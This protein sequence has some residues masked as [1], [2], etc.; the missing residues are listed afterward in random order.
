MKTYNIEDVRVSQFV[1]VQW[2]MYVKTMKLRLIG[3]EKF[4][5]EDNGQAKIKAETNKGII[6][7]AVPPSEWELN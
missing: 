3:Y 2:F 5:I 6:K 1:M 7:M 4:I